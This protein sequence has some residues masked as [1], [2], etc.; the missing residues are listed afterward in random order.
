MEK[1]SISQQEA[2]RKM[3]SERVCE[4]LVSLGC[5]EETVKAMRRMELLLTYA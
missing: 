2:V 3:S 1:V 5:G 4:K